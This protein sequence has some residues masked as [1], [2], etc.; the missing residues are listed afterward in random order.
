MA[1]TQRYVTAGST[2]GG[3]G[4]SFVD[5]WT[6]DEAVAAYAPG[7]VVNVQEDT[8]TLGATTLATSATD[9]GPILWRGRNATDDGDGRPLLNMQTNILALSGEHV[10]FMNFD[11]TSSNITNTFYGSGDNSLAYNCKFYNTGSGE[12]TY[13]AA[14]GGDSN[15]V[16][17]LISS[18]NTN[19]LG[20]TTRLLGSNMV[21]CKIVTKSNGIETSFS[22]R[23]S[24]I[25]NSIIIG[26]GI[27]NGIDFITVEGVV[28]TN[29]FINLT[30][31]NFINGIA[32]NQLPNIAVA[33]N[34]G[35]RNRLEYSVI[36][37]AVNTAARL[38]DAAPGGQVWIGENTL[39]QVQDDINVK[40]LGPVAV[41]GK[42]EP[43]M[44]YEIL[45]IKNWQTGD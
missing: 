37:D 40:P 25:L 10:K 39:T 20:Y 23:S 22:N 31:Y 15:F 6:F 5:Y 28:S 9:Y 4:T 34:M 19:V 38:A 17:C 36:G 44:A 2:I 32:F 7:M 27:N 42:Q 29:V 30:I 43:I 33:G 24:S 21:G 45:D 41:K 3:G 16:N 11:V 26:D 14:R 35:S 13:T 18:D 1:L 12:N 8:Y